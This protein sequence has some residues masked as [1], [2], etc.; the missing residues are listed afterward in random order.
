MTGTGVRDPEDPD[1]WLVSPWPADTSFLGVMQ[2]FQQASTTQLPTGTSIARLLAFEESFRTALA[3][4][5]TKEFTD[6]AQWNWRGYMLELADLSVT[7]LQ[8]QYLT[9]YGHDPQAAE[10]QHVQT[11]KHRAGTQPPRP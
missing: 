11:V 6:Q 5:P 10:D 8:D 7:L 9:Q 1:R 3:A 2:H 4:A